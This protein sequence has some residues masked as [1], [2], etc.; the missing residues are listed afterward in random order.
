M[1]NVI[2]RPEALDQL[3]ETAAY[4]EQHHPAAADRIYTRLRD[5]G[6]SLRSSPRRGRPMPGG[7]RRSVVV[8]PYI[9][10]Y[11]VQGE[12]VYII[13]VRHSARRPLT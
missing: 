11:E 6:D 3:D 4:I 7:L 5:L 2:W 12:T 10:S 1:A 8:Q 9:L 13:R